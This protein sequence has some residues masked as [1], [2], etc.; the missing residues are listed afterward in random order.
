M[1]GYSLSKDG[2]HW[3]EARY[4]PVETKVKK[5][6]TIM[7]TPVC[8]VDEGNDV[9]TIVYAAIDTA[10]RFHP[11]GMVKLKLNTDVLKR[12]SE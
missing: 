8:L 6:W 12:L 7:R 11:M 2:F 4:L 9:Y 10:K 1:M 3:S 5:W